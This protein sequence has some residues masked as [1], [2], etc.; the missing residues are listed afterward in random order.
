[1]DRVC[2][3]SHLGLGKQG[4]E[5]SAENAPISLFAPCFHYTIDYWQ[6]RGWNAA[7]G[8]Y[9]FRTRYCQACAKTIRSTRDQKQQRVVWTCASVEEVWATRTSWPKQL[10]R[11]SP[12]KSAYVQNPEYSTFRVSNVHVLCVGLFLFVFYS[13]LF[14]EC[15]GNAGCRGNEM[16]SHGKGVPPSSC[17]MSH[18]TR[19]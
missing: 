5:S 4:V 10:T 14:W 3:G 15:G 8:S 18:L 2:P 12:Y 19:P 1:M 13:A 17:F 6:H 9:G 16:K 11:S 7:S